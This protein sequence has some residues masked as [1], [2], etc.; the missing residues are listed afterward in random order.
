MGRYLTLVGLLFMVCTVS[1]A[2]IVVNSL[3]Y[4]DV[5]S[6]VSYANII[7]DT[8]SYIYPSTTLPNAI[9]SVGSQEVVLVTSS[10]S[11]VHTGYR[12]GLE[13]NG[14]TIAEELV[15][16]DA[17]TFNME[18]ASRSGARSFVITDPDYT[19][20]C[21]SIFAYAKASGSYILFANKANAAQVSSFL[22]SSSPSAVLIYG[23]VDS[24]VADSLSSSGV[25]FEQVETGDKYSDN[26]ALLRKYFDNYPSPGQITFTDGTFL[27]PSITEGTFPVMFIT[28]TIPTESEE[29]FSSLVADGL[30]NVSVLL[31]LEYYNAFYDLYKRINAEYEEDRLAGFAKM[32]QASSAGGEMSLLDTYPL[33]SVVLQLELSDVQYNTAKEEV[34]L[35]L[36]NS[37]T[38]AAYATSTVIVYSD[39]APVATV[40]DEEPVLI[41]KGETKGVSYPLEIDAPGELS[42]NVTVYYSTSRIA[43]EGALV[44]YVEMGQVDFLDS[45][46]L[47]ITAA[48]YSPATDIVSIKFSNPGDGDVYFSSEVSYST[49]LSSST[50]TSPGVNSLSPGQSTVIQFSGLLISEG[51]LASLEMEATAHYGGREEFL[52]NTV[53]L[54]VQI[55]LEEEEPEGEEGDLLVPLLV[56]AIIIVAVAAYFLLGKKG[57]AASAAP[58]QQPA[59]PRA[60]PKRKGK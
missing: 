33:P 39:G 54:P 48:S 1:S 16:D 20:N 51:E 43:F 19:Y 57:A 42:A 9:L 34:E 2:H 37:G 6:A 8:S 32:G 45:S 44:Q 18:L 38:V 31:E 25:Q 22:S 11:P 41:A 4:R 58:P 24:V 13:N 10:V 29:Y 52:V 26:V 7:G 46:S 12:N 50:L 59:R 55:S 56:V 28:Y 5:V 49:D 14:A 60:A 27:D 40:G 35:V 36:T 3:D 23:S 15:S 30:V 53:S 21:V 47:Q 17:L